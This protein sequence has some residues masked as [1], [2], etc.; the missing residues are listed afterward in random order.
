MRTTS[1]GVFKVATKAPGDV[2]GLMSL[3]G[4]GTWVGSCAR[5]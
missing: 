4:S 2:S 1:V 3:I 5:W